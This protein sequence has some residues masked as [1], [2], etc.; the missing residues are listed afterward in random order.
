MDAVQKVGNGHPG[1]AMSLAPAA[2]LLFQ[3]HLRH[4]PADP[5]VDRSRPVRALHGPLQPHPVPPALPLRVR[6]RARRPAGAAHLGQPHPRP[7]RVGSHRRGRDHDRPARAGS[8]Q[9]RRN[10]AGAATGARPA[11]PRR[12]GRAPARSTGTSGSS[13]ATATCRRA[14]APRPRSLA[15]TQRLGNLTV[16]WDDNRISI[17]DDTHDR[18]HRGR[19]PRGTA[20]TAGTSSR[21]TSPPTAT[22]T[23]SRSTPPSRGPRRARAPRPSSGCALRSP[24]RPPTPPTPG[25]PTAPRSVP[26]RWPPPSGCSGSTR[27]RSRSRST[28]RCCAHA[29]RVVDRGAAAAPPVA[30]AATT[31]GRPPTPTGQRCG[32]GSPR[33]SC[34]TTGGCTCRPSRRE[35]SVATRSASGKTLAALADVLPELWGGS[36]DLARLEQ[37]HHARPAVRPPGGPSDRHVVGQ[38]LR[39]HPALRRPRARHGRPSPTASRSRATPAPTSARSWSSATTCGRRCGWPP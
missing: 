32:N 23:S 24:G 22:S 19:L 30:A 7:P 33:A 1:T 35:P 8:R 25:A 38:P 17:E 14:S 10:G 20:P 15:G 29:R 28:P 5:D 39:P 11:R 34:P 3:R 13:P 2:Y 16:I 18:L 6:P 9:R 26:T 4:D 36:A 31:P 21:S 12:R 37:H 27:R